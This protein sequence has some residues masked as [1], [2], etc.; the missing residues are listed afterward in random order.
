M[1]NK[2]AGAVFNCLTTKNK[3]VKFSKDPSSGWLDGNPIFEW[4]LKYLVGR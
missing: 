1:K 4:I 2:K 3:K